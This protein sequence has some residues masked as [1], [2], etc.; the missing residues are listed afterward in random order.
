MMRELPGVETKK[1]MDKWIGNRPHGIYIWTGTAQVQ[2]FGFIVYTDFY[3][4]NGTIKMA[5]LYGS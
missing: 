4:T 1:T 2:P 5:I 3:Y